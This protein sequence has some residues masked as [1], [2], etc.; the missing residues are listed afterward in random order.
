MNSTST[1]IKIKNVFKPKVQK[2]T[3]MDI[4]SSPKKYV[5]ILLENNFIIPQNDFTSLKSNETFDDFILFKQEYMNRP[6]NQKK[7]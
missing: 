5:E 6:D 3:S 4:V 1:K 2:T 7:S